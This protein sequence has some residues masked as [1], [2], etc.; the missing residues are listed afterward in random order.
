MPPDPQPL[1]EEPVKVG[2][3][4]RHARLLLGLSLKEVAARVGVTEGYLSKIENDRSRPSFDILHRLVQALG[5]NMS[6]LFA[7]AESGTGNLFVLRRGA[8]PKLRTGAA[9]ARKAVS[10]ERLVPSGKAFLLQVNIHRVPPGGASG[11]PIRHRGQEFGYVLEGG[12]ELDVE[13]EVV[14]L[15]PGDVF[16]FDSER[17]HSYRNPGPGECRVLWV[18]TPPTF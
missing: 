12:L 15:G 13:G 11:E 3:K 8:G 16:C 17:G 4:L 1:P 14:A 6:D 7:G 5:T 18:N 10:L 9:G 2:T